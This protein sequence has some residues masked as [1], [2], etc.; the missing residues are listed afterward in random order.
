MNRKLWYIAA[1]LVMAALVFVDQLTKYMARRDLSVLA[2]RRYPII[3]KV[4]SL[5]LV[6]NRGAAWGILQG[7]VDILSIISII[8]VIVI[9]IFFIKIPAAK[10]FNAIRI[11][12]VFVVAGAVGNVIDRIGFG[13]VTDFL[14][15]ELIN[16]PV[17]N[18]ADCYIT[19]SMVI[20][21]F[22]M[23]FYYKDEDLEFF[24]IKKLFHKKID[25]EENNNQIVHNEAKDEGKAEKTTEKK[26]EAEDEGQSD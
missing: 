15:I 18:I 10:K 16:F 4:F 9:F 13:E 5:T 11:L 24:S 3:D 21:A 8:L 6:K 14:N 25:D 2:D 19:F 23:L 12:S 26:V 1:P 20:F 7:R 17:F 22:L